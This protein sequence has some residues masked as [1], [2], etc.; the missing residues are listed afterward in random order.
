MVQAHRVL[1]VVGLHFSH[2]VWRRDALVATRRRRL[3]TLVYRARSAYQH[4]RL[5]AWRRQYIRYPCV[6]AG[7]RLRIGRCRFVRRR[8]IRRK[9]QPPQTVHGLLVHSTGDIG[10][11]SRQG[12]SVR[13]R[14]APSCGEDRGEPPSTSKTDPRR[15]EVIVEGIERVFENPCL[16]ERTDDNGSAPLCEGLRVH[17]EAH[18][19]ATALLDASRVGVGA[20][21]IPDAPCPPLWSPVISVVLRLCS[22]LSLFTLCSSSSYRPC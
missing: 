13:A 9:T 11:H 3:S 22:I 17:M 14:G 7:G 4:H 1:D 8:R 16:L 2:T 18:N 5:W 19:T 15:G 10:L 21:G 20:S 6:D 12:P